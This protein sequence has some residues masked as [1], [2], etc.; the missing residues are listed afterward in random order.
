M[1]NK[2]ITR[3]AVIS[4][5]N[6]MSLMDFR[7]PYDEEVSKNYIR[8]NYLN[9]SNNSKVVMTTDGNDKLLSIK[10]FTELPP[11]EGIELLSD[12]VTWEKIIEVIQSFSVIQYN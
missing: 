2:I 12:G 7:Q 10:L 11:H 1:K 9:K 3:R 6:K 4:F 5:N 8:Y